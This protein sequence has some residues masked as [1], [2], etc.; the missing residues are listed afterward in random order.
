MSP[1]KPPSRLDQAAQFRSRPLVHSCRSS[2]LLTEWFVPFFQLTLRQ[3]HGCYILDLIYKASC[4]G[5]ERVHESMN[6]LLYHGH[7]VL[8]K[9]LLAWLLQGNLFDPYEEFF[10][11]P[12]HLVE[13][14]PLRDFIVVG[15][16][17][18]KL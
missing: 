12:A 11:V 8:Y 5:V 15:W 3:A 18:L 1:T 17:T 14:T 10:I 16:F 6:T 2:P 7:K 13:A 9:Q 4:S